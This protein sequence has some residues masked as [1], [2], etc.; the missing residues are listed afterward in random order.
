MQTLDEMLSRH[1]LNADQHGRIRAW[2][3]AARTP[4]AI[5]EMPADLWR[6]LELASKLLGFDADMQR[7][8]PLGANPE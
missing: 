7:P 4:Q 5:L 2:I 3:A 1:F 8:P 6:S